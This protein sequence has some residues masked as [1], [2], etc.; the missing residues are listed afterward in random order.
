MGAVSHTFESF[1]GNS[2]YKNFGSGELLMGTINMREKKTTKDKK[3]TCKSQRAF[4]ATPKETPLLQP[5]GRKGKGSG[6]GL[7][8]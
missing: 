1:I 4:L 2:N 7:K 3:G 8:E 5:E 6:I